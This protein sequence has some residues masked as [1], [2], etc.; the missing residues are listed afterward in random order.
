MSAAERCCTTRRQNAH[1]TDEREVVYPWHPW[2]GSI[3]QIRQIIE[4]ASG[5]RAR[6]SVGGGA[7]VREI[8]IWMFERS[9]CTLMRLEKSAHVTVG[10]LADLQV[11]LA[12]AQSRQS[13]ES[14]SRIGALGSGAEWTS[15]DESRGDD[16]ATSNQHLPSPP[17]Q[18]EPARAVRTG[19][20]SGC[21]IDAAVAD[22]AG[23]GQRDA[24]GATGSVASG[25]CT[26]RLPSRPGGGSRQ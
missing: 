6:C 10:A 2:A 12:Q 7:L 22:L 23:G 18:N 9:Q 4:T 19:C 14:L 15:Q 5:V 16:H 26:R 3:V 1:G 25:T 8:P 11:L 21:G 20:S 17:N 24:D 13:V